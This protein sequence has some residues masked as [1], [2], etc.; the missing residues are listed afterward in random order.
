MNKVFDQAIVALDAALKAARAG[1]WVGCEPT[2]TDRRSEA[3][4]WLYE[5]L[6]GDKEARARSMLGCLLARRPGSL[7]LRTLGRQ[8]RDEPLPRWSYGLYQR[9]AGARLWDGPADPLAG[10][11]GCEPA[12]WRAFADSLELALRA[13]GWGVARLQM[14]EEEDELRLLVQPDGSEPSADPGSDPRLLRPS[15]HSAAIPLT[16]MRDELA[17]EGRLLLVLRRP[18]LED[19][20][21]PVAELELPA[22]PEVAGFLE[23]VRLLAAAARE[24]ALPGLILCG[25]PPP[26]DESVAWTTL[27]PDPAVIEVNQAPFANLPQFLAGN[28][29]L[30]AVAHEVGLSPYRLHYNGTQSDSGGGGQITLGGHSPVA[31]PF[32]RHPR[33]LP[34]LV[35]YLTRHPA[36][37]YWL[38]PP[39]LG[40]SS[41]GPR[42][43]EGVRDSFRELGLAL[44]RLD[45]GAGQ[46]PEALWSSLSPFLCDY[47]GNPHRSELNIEKLWN[48]YLPGRGCLGLVEFRALRMASSPE[49]AVS[50]AALLTALCALLIR[51]D[52][53]PALHDWGDD[54]HERFALPYYLRQDLKQ[55]LEDLETG[56]LG[57]PEA[58][59]QRLLD[60]RLREIG[61]LEV[62]GARFELSQALEFWPLVGDVASQEGGGSR[63]MDASTGRIQLL[64]RPPE[65][66]GLDPEGWA[67]SCNGFRL[68][69]RPDR[70]AQGP[71]RL[72]GIRYRR[73]E[74]HR[75]L[76][77]GIPV[78]A[79]LQIVLWHP[80][81][82]QALQLS[83]HEWRP[84]KQPYPGLPA[85]RLEAQCRRRERFVYRYI[86]SPPSS[87]DA[88]PG[89]YSA[90]SFDLRRTAAV[91]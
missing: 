44:E 24:A 41:Q 83:V 10:G 61:A 6:G 21:H 54:L 90:Y 63:L 74:P 36:L 38:A 3:P 15:V 14:P 43:D 22:W 79:P 64:M 37:S 88:P 17:A 13:Q 69:L 19:V 27:T 31:S 57:L 68:R 9:R 47:S 33:L 51:H 16:G 58:I 62:G 18:T 5:A 1:I 86:S 32:L 65:S 84:D 35:R 75:G 25:F 50:F 80:E 85:D 53:V 73:F 8:Y 76:H 4:E 56:G 70:D 29:E 55:V 52:P 89:A 39:F 28:R 72:L 46:D 34:R 81:L 71:L 49:R 82:P 59:T 77:P 7:I 66:G 11:V 87:R 30:F 48:P 60:A 2:F 40:S 42:V 20:E 45:Q 91:P 26:V 78:Q 23:F 12:Q 67:L